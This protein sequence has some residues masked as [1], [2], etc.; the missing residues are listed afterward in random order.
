MTT[1]RTPMSP[2]EL[3]RAA[4]DHLWLHFTRMGAYGDSEV[5]II[6]RGDGCYLEDSKGKRYL[7]A[8]AGLFAVQIGYSYGDEVGRAAH[9]ADEGAA[10]LYQLVVRASP[11]D[12][13]CPRG[14]ATGAGRSQ[15]RVLRLRRLG[16]GR[17]RVEARA[18]VP[19]GARRAPVEGDRPPHRVPRHD[20]GR[21]LD[22]RHRRDQ[23]RVRAARSRDV[24]RA[25]HEPLPPARGGDGGAV[26]RVPARRPRGGDHRGWAVDGGDG[27]HGAGA[28]RGRRV[29]PAGRTTSRACARSATATGS[30][31]VPTR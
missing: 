9:D 3:Q 5:P 7:D 21:A 14:G 1:S 28:E 18:P 4:R 27:D 22:Q 6:V 20:D 29:H 12:R 23:E 30:C 10:L 19:L 24:P 17:V 2:E 16:G 13:A 8:L 25:E 26:H 31:S 15:P 11:R